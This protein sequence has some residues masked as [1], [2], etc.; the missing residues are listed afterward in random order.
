MSNN[1][2]SF[3][4]DSRK[5][6]I[7]EAGITAIASKGYRKSSIAD[8][9][10]SAG[11]SKSLVLYHFPDKYHL[12]ISLLNYSTTL[13]SNRIPIDQ[14]L[15]LTDLFDRITFAI[16]KKMEL[17]REHPA[18]FKFLHR[19][20]HDDEPSLKSEVKKIVNIKQFQSQQ[21]ALHNID[22]SRFKDSIDVNKIFQ[23]ITY[24]TEGFFE[25]HP[26]IES[27]ELENTISELNSYL[28]LLKKSF[29]LED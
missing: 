7:I 18:I 12:A 2:N 22:T 17:L 20:L 13:I 26:I 9:A 16:Q 25:S 6:L 27:K 10:K 15:A 21:T 28:A 11:V 1:V 5:T 24:L 14:M 3:T 23:M 19:M 29:Y 4:N 8:I